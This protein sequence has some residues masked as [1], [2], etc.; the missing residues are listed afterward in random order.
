[1]RL[2]WDAIGPPSKLSPL[3]RTIRHIDE[4]LTHIFGEV[5]RLALF[6]MMHLLLRYHCD[7]SP[8]RAAVLPSFYSRTIDLAPE[9]YVQNFLPWPGRREIFKNHSHTSRSWKFFKSVDYYLRIP[10]PF[11]IE[12]CWTRSPETGPFLI[13]SEFNR[14]IWHLG[15]WTIL[16]E[17]FEMF[18]EMNEIFPH[19]SYTPRPFEFRKAEGSRQSSGGNIT[20]SKL[21]AEAFENP[22]C[23]VRCLG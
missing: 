5:E 17:M 20:G 13:H 21:R 9:H 10:C 18:P 11:G 2:G 15:D 12:D 4:A 14:R 3:W 23:Q 16:P 19:A 7:P 6:R 22:F 8:T 1:M